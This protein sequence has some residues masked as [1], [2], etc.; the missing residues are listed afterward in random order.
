[1]ELSISNC[2]FSSF[3]GAFAQAQQLS[4]ST[5]LAFFR[6]SDILKAAKQGNAAA[7]QHFLYVNPED[8]HRQVPD[9][10]DKG[11]GLR[12]VDEGFCLKGR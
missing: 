10:Q 6:G 4:S 7:V 2:F 12:E 8:V 11:N 3:F 5:W 1:M 9:G